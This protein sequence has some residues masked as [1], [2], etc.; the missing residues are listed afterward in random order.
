MKLST[1]LTRSLLMA[2]TMV[3]GLAGTAP[4]LAQDTGASEEIITVTA[5]RREES[6]QDVPLSVSAVSGE[7]L[8][9]TGAVDII[10]IAD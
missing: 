7:E 4:A 1:K 2:S 8:E 10:A 3:G 5:R 9:R 6:L